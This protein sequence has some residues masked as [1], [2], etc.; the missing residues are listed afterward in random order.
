[1][2]ARIHCDLHRTAMDSTSPELST[3][4]LAAVESM[5]AFPVCVQSILQLTRQADCSPRDLVEVIDRDPVMTVKILRV[6]N[7]VYYSLPRK[8]ASIEQAVVFLGF[9]P[10]KNL[11]LG[12]AAV[13]MLPRN[14]VVGFE[15]QRYLMHSLATAGI[16]RALTQRLGGTDPHD[17]FIAGLLHD[18]GTVLV[19]Q[20]MPGEYRRAVEY[21]AWHAI[22]VHQALLEMARVNQSA[23]GAA[24]LELW[25]FPQ[26]LVDAMRNQ[27][28]LVDASSDL[29]VAVYSA[30]Y[31]SESVGAG[32][33]GAP[34]CPAFSAIASERLGGTLQEILGALGDLAP[35]L[36][37]ARRFSRS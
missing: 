18:F 6:V 14:A 10:I 2:K 3:E 30:N 36:E 17:F 20:V 31:I 24:L 19:A 7:S 33:G 34:V 25:R 11:A 23:I 16:A 15:G 5:Q 4:L 9:N 26:S 28:Q 35:V 1:M 37:E 13:G 21:A 8:I 29:C 22:P 27:H 12:V 32:F